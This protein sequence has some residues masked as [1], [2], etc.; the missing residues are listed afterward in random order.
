MSTVTPRRVDTVLA[1]SFEAMNSVVQRCVMRSRS[2]T[3]VIE[4]MSRWQR[5]LE[6]IDSKQMWPA[7]NWK[8]NTEDD[9]NGKITTL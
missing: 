8:G 6:S 3:E 5:L 4:I 2:S 7:I 1:A 9:S